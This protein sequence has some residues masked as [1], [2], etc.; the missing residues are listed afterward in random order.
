MLF[1]VLS[2]RRSLY[3]TRRLIE[4]AARRGHEAIVLDPLQCSL[5]LQTRS[6][7]LYYRDLDSRLPRVDVVVPR[8][9]A[10]VTEAGLAVVNQIDMMGVPL[11]NDAPAISRS[12][13]KLRA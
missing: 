5:G 4:A 8:I 3:S 10:S 12:R 1:A 7:A 6:P 13:D 2:R 9:G 11:I